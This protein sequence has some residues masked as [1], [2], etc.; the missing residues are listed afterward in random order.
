VPYSPGEKFTVYRTA[1]KV[2]V[3][4]AEDVY[5]ANVTLEGWIQ[6]PMLFVKIGTL[7]L[8]MV[9]QEEGVNIVD[10]AASGDALR[11]SGRVLAWWKRR[12]LDKYIKRT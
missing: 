2:T 8:P 9:S 4:A 1:R 12:H 5:D 6:V 11:Q 7:S 3:T 10:E